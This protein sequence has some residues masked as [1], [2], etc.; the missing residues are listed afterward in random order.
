MF[1][2]D[3]SNKNFSQLIPGVSVAH[4]DASHHQSDPVK[5]DQYSKINRWHVEQYVYLLERMR[6]IREG[7]GTLLDN[8]MMLLGSGTSD[9]NAHAPD[10]LPILLAGR[11][12]GAIRSGRHLRSEKNTPLCN[13]YVSV[14]ERLGV[15]T[16]RFGDSTKPLDLS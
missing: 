2:N 9:G 7:E 15:P 13:V 14:L 10:N 4:H 11:G 12:G 3:V 5:I 6:A 16:K 1:A 8:S